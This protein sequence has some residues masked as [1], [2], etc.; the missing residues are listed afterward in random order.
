MALSGYTKLFSFTLNWASAISP[1]SVTSINWS[2]G[3]AT[4]ICTGHGFLNG[5]SV[6]ISGASPSGY[7]GEYIIAYVDDNTF[8]YP[9]SDPGGT[10][11]TGTITA[12]QAV[13][14]FPQLLK[15]GVLTWDELG[16]LYDGCAEDGRDF[17]LED[18]DDLGTALPYQI[19]S[20]SDKAIR[21]PQIYFSSPLD[22][23]NLER[24]YNIYGKNHSQSSASGSAVWDNADYLAVYHLEEATGASAWVDAT[25]NS[26][27]LDSVVDNPVQTDAVIGKGQD[28]NQSGDRASR[29]KFSELIGSDMS[30]SCFAK[31][32]DLGVADGII[33]QGTSANTKG[34]YL[35]F[36][37]DDTLAFSFWGASDFV[38]SITLIDYTDKFVHIGTN[39]RNDTKL[40]QVILNGTLD[41]SFTFASALVDGGTSFG[42]GRNFP[43]GGNEFNGI[44]DEV[45]VSNVAR[46]LEW[47]EAENDLIVEAETIYSANISL[48]DAGWKR[49]IK[50]TARWNDGTEGSNYLLP[51]QISEDSLSSAQLTAFMETPATKCNPDAGE[52]RFALS[53]SATTRDI[54]GAYIFR[55]DQLLKAFDYF[56]QINQDYNIGI[57]GVDIYCYYR[58]GQ[59]SQPPINEK[60][61][62]KDCFNPDGNT[63]LVAPL[64]SR[65][66]TVTN[67]DG[68][69]NNGSVEG[70]NNL[71]LV[72]G[73]APQGR[74][75]R[76]SSTNDKIDF[77]NPG[78]GIFNFWTPTGNG[79]VKSGKI[80]AKAS[81]DGTTMPMFGKRDNI[82]P[83]AGS[84]FQRNTSNKLKFNI[85]YGS[86]QVDRD[87]LTDFVIA[88]GWVHHSFRVATNTPQIGADMDI[89]RNGTLD[90]DISQGSESGGVS[91]TESLSIGTTH[92]NDASSQYKGELS[93]ACLYSDLREDA[94]F[95]CDYQMSNPRLSISSITSSGITATVTT[96]QD[97]HLTDEAI[98]VILGAV[99]TEYNGEYGIT[100]TGSNTFTYTFAGS[101]TSPAT[102]T[103]Q[104]YGKY[105]SA[106][107]D[108][109][110]GYNGES[111]ILTG[112]N[113]Y[114]EC[115]SLNGFSTLEHY[116][117]IDEKQLGVKATAFWNK[118][119]A[120]GGDLI[121]QY[122]NNPLGGDLRIPLFVA[123]CDTV[124]QKLQLRVKFLN[125]PSGNDNIRI[126][127]NSNRIEQQPP[128]DGSKGWEDAQATNTRNSTPFADSGTQALDRS[129]NPT[130][131]T[132][133]NGLPVLVV[134][135]VGQGNDLERSLS[136]NA[137]SIGLNRKSTT[138]ST[139]SY[140]LID[141]TA[142]YYAQQVD[143]GEQ[144]SNDTTGAL[145]YVITI[146]DKNTLLLTSDIFPSVGHSYIVSRSQK[147]APFANH[148]YGSAWI[149]M[150]SLAGIDMTIIAKSTD[151]DTPPIGWGFR[152]GWENQDQRLYTILRYESALNK[153]L[154]MK[155][156]NQP[157]S[158]GT[159]YKASF[160]MKYPYNSGNVKMWIN[161]VSQGLSIQAE[162]AIGIISGEAKYSIGARV[163][164]TDR[165]RYFDGVVQQVRVIIGTDW[166]DEMENLS[167][168][169]ENNTEDY[170]SL[171][172][173]ATGE[174]SFPRGELTGILKGV[175]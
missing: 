156:T 59:T 96:A 161:K 7:N 129:A 102:G 13:K 170:W 50:F 53:S 1:R 150:E 32:Q 58:R 110:I 60:G 109:E 49:R 42:L 73:D 93:M 152:V 76:Y 169:N 5:S 79:L 175:I 62:A 31:R 162:N 19:V 145:A 131:L 67:L 155:T 120:G 61:G 86:S 125:R 133:M 118:V 48:V 91:R 47:M 33:S 99:Q 104:Y 171:K 55:H 149:K 94:F 35:Q 165:S 146:L 36:Q 71:P 135:Q 95:L 40:A 41:A 29:T 112:W 10:P 168:V 166:T 22:I 78:P 151:N 154:I 126:Y 15:K 69:G 119:Q 12:K 9:I 115:F 80:W 89:L 158:L 148:I 27:N 63:L 114:F 3:L 88:D 81:E 85:D 153:D 64:N 116:S 65:E 52:L 2:G 127:F 72:F 172:A 147:L 107:D 30:I 77:G 173:L 44:L 75:R 37:G 82:A 167:F 136:Q 134:G 97:H 128:R 157:F 123:R 108:T 20:W 140:L 70:P 160:L 101:G 121:A 26:Y 39:F 113:D 159:W 66:L 28:F 164:Q 56:V 38:K 106:S 45:R 139:G 51:V 25:G 144:V 142:D 132:Y 100:V 68:S 8:T 84:T 124:N 83:N 34:L 57:G 18:N 54:L 163:N 141:S 138:T 143:T 137:E 111:D 122:V 74:G 24:M 16:I 98:V 11:A 92:G 6:V 46:S 130:N 14:N 43:A 87:G 23:N 103:L 105:V 90:N 4:V 21:E 17:R 117:L 174:R